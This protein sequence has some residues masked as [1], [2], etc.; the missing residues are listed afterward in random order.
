M[1]SEADAQGGELGRGL[2]SSSEYQLE[3]ERSSKGMFTMM[4]Y[5]AVDDGSLGI[6]GDYNVL[7]P[8]RR[9][10]E[11]ATGHDTVAYNE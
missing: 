10:G 11:L 6:V 4:A 3:K 5:D 2:A 8:A 7:L 1:Q 9:R